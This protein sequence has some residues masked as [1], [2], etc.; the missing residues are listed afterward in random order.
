MATHSSVLAWGIPGTG[1][2]GGLTSL[3]SHRV[4]HDWSDLAAADSKCFLFSKHFIVLHFSFKF[5]M[6]FPA[7]LRYNWHIIWCKF[8][9]YNM[10]IWCTYKY[11]HT[12]IYIFQSNYQNKVSLV[13]RGV[14]CLFVILLFWLHWVFVVA[15][16]LPVVPHRLLLL[17]HKGFSS[18]CRT[19][20][21]VAHRLLLLWSM[22][23]RTHGLSS[24]G[25]WA[26]VVAVQG[27][28]TCSTRT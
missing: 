8:K 28:F 5:M 9:V 23:S 7:L 24:G 19:S 13:W 20:L 10:M 15:Q 18:W 16:G 21:A 6:H 17:W 12:Y 2:P 22:D 25:M 27:L 11:I 26:S 3:G 4:R 1:E 14:V